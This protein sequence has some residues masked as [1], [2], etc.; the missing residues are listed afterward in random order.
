MAIPRKLK[1]D[2]IAEALFE[3][4]FQSDEI[5]EVVIANLLVF[6][7]WRSFDKARLP[8]ADVPWPIQVNDPNLNI[9]PHVQLTKQDRTEAGKIGPLVASYH[10][11][12]PYSGWAVFS[13]HIQALVAHCFA[14]ING[15]QVTRAGLR[16][17]NILTKADHNIGQFSDLLLNV[18]VGGRKLDSHMTLHYAV[19]SGTAV[20]ARITLSSPEMVSGPAGPFSALI[21][22][23]VST[24]DGFEAK[25]PDVVMSWLESAHQFEKEQFFSLIP[26]AILHTLV[27]E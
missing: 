13:P 1:R 3:I 19:S 6:D 2:A 10:M 8:A 23:D 18:N 15:F 17:I 22:V 26:E 25:S 27:E 12:A 4:R 9:Q 16:Y 11:L 21:D 7:R 20:Q 14:S 5:P 24:P